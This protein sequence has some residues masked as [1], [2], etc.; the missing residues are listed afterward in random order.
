MVSLMEAV[1]K[2]L[3]SDNGLFMPERIEEFSPEF[4]E[5]IQHLSFQEISFEVAKNFF[6]E[7]LF[8]YLDF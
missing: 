6:G 1:T 7:D 4:F 5:Q 3:A 8:W 2:G